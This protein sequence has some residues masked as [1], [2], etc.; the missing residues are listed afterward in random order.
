MPQLVQVELFNE[1][2]DNMYNVTVRTADMGLGIYYDGK[3]V[4]D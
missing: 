4:F 2:D 3:K 1:L